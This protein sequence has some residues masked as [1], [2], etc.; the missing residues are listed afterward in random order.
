MSSAHA[1]APRPGVL[2]ATVRFIDGFQ[3]LFALAIR[4]YVA[5]V[6]LLSGLTKIQDWNITVALFENEYQVPLLSPAVAAAIGTAAELALPA[7]LIVGLGT[8]FAAL[9]LFAFNIVAVVSYPDLSDAG[10]KDHILWG[11]LLLVAFFHGPGKWS[12]DRLF[13]RRLSPGAP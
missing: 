12:L 13:Q 4:L 7:L 9:G 3:S 2:A 11:A 5:R 10:L 1:S 8:R 6:F